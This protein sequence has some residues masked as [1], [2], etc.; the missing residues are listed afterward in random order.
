MRLR[1]AALG[2]ILLVAFA[3]IGPELYPVDPTVVDLANTVAPRSA[4]H[5]LGTDESGRDVLARLMA[6]GRVTLLVGVGA[7]LVAL[8]VGTTIGGLAAAR[9]PWLEALVSRLLDAAMAVPVFFILL[10]VVTL[11][12]G[13]TTTLVVAIGAT[14]W[15]GIARLVRAEALSLRER[16][17]VA[18]ARALGGSSTR[19]FVRHLLPH[20]IPTLSAAFGIGVSQAVLT[21]SALS[22]LGL[23]VQPPRPSWGNM[24]T[25]AQPN[26]LAA[27]WLAIYPG[28]LIVASVLACH[29]I[30]ERFR[31]EAES[32]L[33]KS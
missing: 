25:G 24:L 33:R 28:L 10:V 5:P 16:D 20:L 8:L 19:V 2:L 4:A 18:V 15:I 26:L 3:V 11:F 22:Y 14:A 21:E 6:G 27:P 7:G 13:A 32:A 31:A 17:Y 9:R 29:A 1:S 30:A 23:G 12:G